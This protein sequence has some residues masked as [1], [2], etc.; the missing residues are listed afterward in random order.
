MAS[1]VNF[2]LR[3]KLSD[4]N[5][6]CYHVFLASTC[7]YFLFETDGQEMAPIDHQRVRSAHAGKNQL[8]AVGVTIPLDAALVHKSLN[9][10]DLQI[11]Y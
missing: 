4:V 10:C 11:K 2:D 3:I 5:Y 9:K 1:G 7:F 8:H 6:L